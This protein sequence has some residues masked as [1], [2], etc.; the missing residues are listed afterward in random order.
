VP[1]ARTVQRTRSS[2][3]RRSADTVSACELLT[4]NP[5]HN[6]MRHEPIPADP[7]MQTTPGKR[8]YPT[9]WAYFA[10]KGSL[11]RIPLAQAPLAPPGKPR[12][13]IANQGHVPLAAALRLASSARA[14]GR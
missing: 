6:S 5:D 4:T 12:S 3:M 7:L 2:R 9:T 1:P 13:K 11:V 14:A 10:S 8:R